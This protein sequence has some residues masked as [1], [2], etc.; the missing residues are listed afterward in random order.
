VQLTDAEGREQSVFRSDH[1]LHVLIDLEAPVPVVDPMVGIA[2]HDERDGLL[3]GVN[4]D[5]VEVPLGT[6]HGKTRV[7]FVCKRIPMQ[8]GKYAITVGVTTL[9]HRTVYH[10]Q[11]RAH[12]FRCEGPGITSGTLSVPVEIT[13]SP[14]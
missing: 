9:D 7:E 3:L 10:W 4:S 6:L 11:E 12:Q 14:L 5:M 13:V 8:E 1:D 2:I